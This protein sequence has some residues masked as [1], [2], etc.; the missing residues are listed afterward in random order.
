MGNNICQVQ[1]TLI[2]QELSQLNETQINALRL[3][4]KLLL[5]NMPPEMKKRLSEAQNDTDTYNIF[6]ELM[7]MMQK[8]RK[9]AVDEKGSDL[10]EAS[11]EN[12]DY[13]NEM[14]KA[15]AD[16]AALKKFVNDPKNY[17]QDGLMNLN[18]DVFPSFFHQMFSNERAFWVDGKT[19]PSGD[20]WFNKTPNGA[21]AGRLPVVQGAVTKDQQMLT[22]IQSSLQTTMS[23]KFA[24][25]TGN[26]T[27]YA[28]SL[29]QD[30]QFFSQMLANWMKG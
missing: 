15:D 20:Q 4:A 24:S 2:A 17:L 13:Q 30:L 10:Q 23:G 25:D 28:Q 14:A 1:D 22:N 5:Q 16:E 6:I 19:L 29:N 26:E 18:W 12:Q 21:F 8:N 27:A 7:E 11:R 9:L 3:V